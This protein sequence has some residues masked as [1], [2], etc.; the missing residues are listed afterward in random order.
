M[1]IEEMMFTALPHGLSA[2]GRH[3]RV[4]AFLT[5]R[6]RLEP[7]DKGLLAEF[8][9]V[10]RWPTTLEQV[11]WHV[12]IQGAGVFAAGLDPESPRA[13]QSAWDLLFS[14]K[15]K[16]G[17]RKFTDYSERRI[18]SFPVASIAEYILGLYA[19]TAAS[20]PFA[21]P[22]TSSLTE[23]VPLAGGREEEAVLEN[24]FAPGRQRGARAR[25]IDLSARSLSAD[26]ERRFAFALARR[27]YQRPELQTK[28]GPLNP[29][30]VPARPKKPA[31]EFHQICA[32]LCDYPELLRHLG[33]AVDLVI[34]AA[35]VPQRG[36]LRIEPK[37]PPEPSW[38]P[39]GEA[40]RPWT[41]FRF[42]RDRLFVPLPKGEAD[43]VVDGMLNLQNERFLVTALDVDGSA[44]KLVGLARTVGQH[45]GDQ[46]S[47]EQMSLPALRDGGVTIVRRERAGA[48][49]ARVDQAARN[50]QAIASD[51]AAE[52]YAQDV[53]RGYRLDV[54]DAQGAHEW[55]SLTRRVGTYRL[56]RGAGG[57]V[58]LPIPLGPDEGYVKGA[59]ATSSAK[60]PEDLYQHEALL[61]WE[62][63]SAVTARP[64]ATLVGEN[65]EEPPAQAMKGF[66]LLATFEPEPG[67]LPLLRFGRHYRV[68]ARA[69]D[70]AGNSHSLKDAPEHFESEEVG[71]ARFEPVSSP[72][73]LALRPF[74]EGESLERVVI[75]STLGESAKTYVALKRVREL[76]AHAVAGPGGFD[77][78][79]RATSSRHVLP[80]KTSQLMAERHGCF[81]AAM[82]AHSQAVYDSFFDLADRSDG[83]FLDLAGAS[84]VNTL[85]PDNATAL[86]LPSKGQPL[87]QGE[88]VVVEPTPSGVPY[89]PDYLAR[90]ATFRQLPGDPTP[91]LI[92]FG[93]SWPDLEPFRLEVIDGTAAPAWDASKRTLTVSLPQ[94]TLT[95]VHLSCHLKREDLE[96]LA[97]W[98][99]LGPSEQGALGA[100]IAIGEHW[101]FT[102]W[103]TLTLVHAVEK[104]LSAPVIELDGGTVARNPTETFCSIGGHVLNHS[105]STGRLDLDAKW[106]Q[107]LDDPRRPKPE[108]ITGQAHV[109]DFLVQ[110]EEAPALTGRDEVDASGV[111]VHRARHEFGDTKHRLVGYQAKA[112]TRYREYFPA[113]IIDDPTLITDLG[114]EL[115]L[116]VPSARR[117]DP[118]EIEYVLPTFRWSET[119]LRARGRPAVFQ[120]ERQGGSLRVYLRR[121]WFS[122][123]DDE[124]LAVVLANQRLPWRE[125]SLGPLGSILR[126]ERGD[127]ESTELDPALIRNV[128][129]RLGGEVTPAR[130]RSALADA[131]KERVSKKARIELTVEEQIA[132]VNPGLVAGFLG[133][134]DTSGLITEW[135]VDPAWAGGALPR[136]PRLQSFPGAERWVTDLVPEEAWLG[137]VAA[138]AFT[139]EYDEG[140]Q[141][142]R[143]DLD[144]DPGQAYF[145]FIRLALA[146]YQ[147]YSLSGLELSKVVHAD[148]A[149]LL[150]HRT[151]AVQADRDGL[152]IALAGTAGYDWRGQ[153]LS[154]FTGGPIDRSLLVRAYLEV[155]TVGG[156]LDWSRV[157]EPIVLDLET[158]D[159]PGARWEAIL[160]LPR[161][162]SRTA[163]RVV[164]E[165]RE[166]YETDRSQATFGE[167]RPGDEWPF[168]P[169]RDRL[170]YVDHFPLEVADGRL[171]PSF[172]S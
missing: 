84:V 164:L 138:A 73:L 66:P 34:E 93:D 59:S 92:P 78:S 107:W 77:W 8:G 90:G 67:S 165:E 29:N 36:E 82:G 57:V 140:R 106:Q 125:I 103:L 109:T 172:S 129:R 146:R 63:W 15:T 115:E 18:W 169:L 12:A 72:E 171:V 19:S 162:E 137:R 5:P 99:L 108:R 87:E 24:W 152:R 158:G 88:Y 51:T 86:P 46:G 159:S 52:L 153:M 144:I 39:G 2:D 126:D 111:R 132:E 142:W 43:D 89:L 32:A 44:L 114:S 37:A 112:T 154:F 76:A 7:D 130:V 110:Y 135:G 105:H 28:R 33:L 163:Y 41:A 65:P 83:T 56:D 156:E 124:Q 136:G 50:D 38:L 58:P 95:R 160:G 122:S 60:A 149:Q 150:P 100:R 119:T 45:L 113:E 3:A 166:L 101:M 117:P 128:A 120:R 54:I 121:P 75:R 23:L 131:I 104:P 4:T 98:G 22:A 10:R 143:V 141:M 123:G 79:Y 102:P 9:D 147:R 42:D 21:F 167:A 61:G 25:W 96:L 13:E 47:D 161:P 69:V 27:F 139:P 80:P 49:A 157:T 68:R 48:V 133:S 134:S 53:T 14:D 74:L 168:L 1:P 71:Y 6:L 70:L 16:V 151:G 81:D 64:G 17:T 40:M 118:P 26:D 94:G 55:R 35:R 116:H 127:V 148:F 170:V 91:Q 97:L 62:G 145:P 85:D 31:F 30:A 155:N 11:A 20:S